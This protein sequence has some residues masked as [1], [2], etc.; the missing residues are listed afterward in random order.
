MNRHYLKTAQVA[1]SLGIS[2]ATLYR[3]LKESKIPEPYRD[4]SNNYRLWTVED[5]E[6]IRRQA[7][8]EAR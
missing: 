7:V 3:W 8:P 6:R 1:E 4:P 5:V 2:L